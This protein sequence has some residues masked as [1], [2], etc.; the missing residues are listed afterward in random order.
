MKAAFAYWHT[1]IAPVF[2]SA[3]DFLLVESNNEEGLPEQTASFTGSTNPEKISWLLGLGVNVVVC[4]AITR[5]FEEMITVQGLSVRSFIAGELHDVVKAWR[6]G[7]IDSASFVMPGC[8]G[9]RLRRQRSMGCRR[10]RSVGGKCNR[11]HR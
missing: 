8:C 4:G 9:Q 11:N 3:R 7:N 2:D 5:Q 6:E 10:Q 1:R